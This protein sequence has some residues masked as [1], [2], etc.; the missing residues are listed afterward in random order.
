LPMPVFY[1]SAGASARV[2]PAAAQNKTPPG[3][4]VRGGVGKGVSFR[5]FCRS[6]AEGPASPV[7]PSG[8]RACSR[9]WCESVQQPAWGR[10]SLRRP[11]AKHLAVPRRQAGREIPRT[12]RARRNPASAASC[13]L[14]SQTASLRPA[15]APRSVRRLSPQRQPVQ[16]RLRR[17]PG[18]SPATNYDLPLNPANRSCRK[19]SP[20][21]FRAA[22][23]ER[24][25]PV[26][27]LPPRPL[28]A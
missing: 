8:T 11:A 10:L 16:A 12:R 24:P 3:W 7:W 20:R 25:R 22:C 13:P 2:R 1:K 21:S 4:L 23:R 28:S 17:A 19:F 6:V 15:P 27:P 26:F 18:I 14:H 9:S 5:R